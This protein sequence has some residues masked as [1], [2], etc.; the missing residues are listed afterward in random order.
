MTSPVELGVYV[1]VV[2]SGRMA[3]C[4]AFGLEVLVVDLPQRREDDSASPQ[5]G[6]SLTMELH[7]GPGRRVSGL[8]TVASLGSSP[9]GGFQRLHLDVTELDDDGEERLSAFLSARRKDSHLDIVASRDVEA[10]HTRAGWDDVR[11]PHVALPEA[12]PDDANL[13]TTFLGRALAA[14]VLIAG[15]TGGT[16]RAGAVNRALARVA[17]E[18]GLG[19]GLGSQRAMVEDPS[20]LSSFRVRAEAPD[21]LLLAN[22]GAVQLSHGVSADDCRRLVGE[23]E[24]DAL[25]IHLNPLQEMIQPEGDRDWRNLRPLIETVVTSVGVPVVLKE[26]GCGLSG[27]MALLAREMGVAAIDVGG[28]GGTAWGFIEGF[29]AADEQHQA[30]GATFRDWGIPTAE[31]LDQCREALGP[32]FPIIAT[33]GVRHGLD[34]ARAIGLGANL[35]GMALPFFRAADVSQDAALALGTRILE[36]LRIAMFCAGA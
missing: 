11:L 5:V 34:V 2:L 4:C 19:M 16:E 21:I 32:D 30:M 10:A 13:G 18:L 17:Q 1:P 24:A 9:P 35:A 28:T 31:A 14:P 22:I 23:V 6:E 29:R 15:M 33:G 36:E 8:A 3:F 26:T 7:L 27:D 12:H 25:A 20:L